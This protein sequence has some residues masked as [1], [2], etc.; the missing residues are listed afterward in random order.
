[1]ISQ[2]EDDPMNVHFDISG[3]LVTSDEKAAIR[4][5]TRV[6]SDGRVEVR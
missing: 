6:D 5:E 2:I 1:M 3:D 4:L